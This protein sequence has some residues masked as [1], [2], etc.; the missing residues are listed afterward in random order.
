MV[1]T[2]MEPTATTSTATI[3]MA[4]GATQAAIGAAAR[5]RFPETA[6]YWMLPGEQPNFRTW[7]TTVENYL[8][9]LERHAAPNDPITNEDKNRLVY[10]LL[11]AEGTAR[12]ASNPSASRLG[13]DTFVDFSGAV[14]RFFQP[15]VNPLCAHF[16]F[17]RRHQL[18]GE[19]AAEFL[20]ALRTLLIDCDMQDV[21]VPACAS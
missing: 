13:Q 5:I 1:I 7:W 16:D 2:T 20:G 11:G 12:F 4:G 15:Q 3:Y 9:W 18:E 21:G 6:A 17:Q 19:S 14:R 8:Y 10:S